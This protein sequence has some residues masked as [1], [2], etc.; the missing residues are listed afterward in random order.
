[1]TA[2]VPFNQ[3]IVDAVDRIENANA[4][5]HAIRHALTWGCGL[6]EGYFRAGSVSKFEFESGCVHLRRI[7]NQRVALQDLREQ[8]LAEGLANV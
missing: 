4:E 2:P 7:A 8:A 1:M 6:L 3:S 5:T